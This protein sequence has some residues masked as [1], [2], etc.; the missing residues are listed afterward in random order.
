MST[1]CSIDP[2]SVISPELTKKISSALSMVFKPMCNDHSGRRGRKLA[3]DFL[4][5]LFGDGIDVGCRFVQ[6]QQF[7]PSQHRSSKRDE[8]LLSQAD[9]VSAGGDDGVQALRKA[10]KRLERFDSSRTAASCWLE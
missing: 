1:A 5:Q 4:E 3:K 9:A 10:E 8:L 6:D 7:G 2:A